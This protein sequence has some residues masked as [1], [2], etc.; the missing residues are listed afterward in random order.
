[1]IILGLEHSAQFLDIVASHE[2]GEIPQTVMWG[3]CPTR[4]DPSQA[5]AGFHTAFMWEKL[6]YG[7]RGNPENWDQEREKHAR[8]MLQ[9]WTEY[10]P[11]L[12][13]SLLDYSA[14]TPLTP[15]ELFRTCEG[16]TFWSA[17]CRMA[18]P[19]IIGPLPALDVI[20][21]TFR[22]FTS[23]VRPATRAVIS[24]AFPDITALRCC[25]PDLGIELESVFGNLVRP[26]YS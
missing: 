18:K 16:E 4:F 11:N 14:Q 2:R 3:S 5:P 25:W 1:M 9:T 7:L 17:L 22:I 12:A 21:R 8:R 26:R 19:A 10:A 20:E 13:D 6:P 15:N 24:P 23:A